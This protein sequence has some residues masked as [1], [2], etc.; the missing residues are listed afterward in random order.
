MGQ[1]PICLDAEI[2]SKPKYEDKKKWI[3]A[4]VDIVECNECKKAPNVV[5]IDAEYFSYLGRVVNE[6]KFSRVQIY[7]E[8]LCT[9]NI[10]TPLE[11][12]TL[13]NVLAFWNSHGCW[14]ERHKTKVKLDT[15]LDEW[16]RNALPD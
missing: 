14:R 10:Y 1:Q 9:Y 12:P 3:G 13:N 16:V 11:G 8:N 4:E 6:G 15:D 5:A 7:C 2:R